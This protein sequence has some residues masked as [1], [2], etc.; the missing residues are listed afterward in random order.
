[1]HQRR[2]KYYLALCAA[3]GGHP[4]MLI[5]CATSL[6]CPQVKGS[7]RICTGHACRSFGLST[8]RINS[9]AYG[10]AL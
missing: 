4:H 10:S 6:E 7:D 3:F 8:R 1:M 5:M 9:Q 2:N